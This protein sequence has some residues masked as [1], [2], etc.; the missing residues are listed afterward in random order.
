MK[1]FIK[2][3]NV[4]RLFFLVFSMFLSF[5]AQSLM[6]IFAIVY[7]S[8][9]AYIKEMFDEENFSIGKVSVMLKCFFT[10]VALFICGSAGSYIIL[11][12]ILYTVNWLLTDVF[13]VIQ[14]FYMAMFV[15]VPIVF[16]LI[17]YLIQMKTISYIKHLNRN[18]KF[19]HFIVSSY[20]ICCYIF[21]LYIID[22]GSLISALLFMIGS[23]T[24]FCFA[25]AKE[26]AK[27][28]KKS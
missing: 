4:Q 15:F 2:S 14:W 28:I 10:S 20:I 5:A 18:Q 1:D 25:V 3:F 19:C 6:P 27:L 26:E 23:E 21:A 13:W 16:T 11:Y 24:C 22:F 12:I 8:I 9:L 17:H 7:C